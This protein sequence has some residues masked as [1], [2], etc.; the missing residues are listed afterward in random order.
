MAID[1]G[2]LHPQKQAIIRLQLVSLLPLQGSAYM[3]KL[4]ESLYPN[5][6]KHSQVNN[7]KVTETHPYDFMAK[8]VVKA[9]RQITYLSKPQRCDS[10]K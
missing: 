3:F 1:L 10:V 2:K 9:D 6:Q 5:Y 4:H 8:I 7:R